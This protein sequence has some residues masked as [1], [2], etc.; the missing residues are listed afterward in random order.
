MVQ[1]PHT[2]AMCVSDG[3]LS[4]GQGVTFP[5]W[6]N[7]YSRRFAEQLFGVYPEWAE[8]AAPDPWPNAAPGCFMLEVPSP[9]HPDRALSVSTARGEITVEF[10]AHG[11]HQHYDLPGD[12]EA[13]SFAEALQAI[14]DIVAE[15]K[16]LAT[17]FRD[18]EPCA[19]TLIPT[20]V[21]PDLNGYERV[22][23]T[24][25]CGTYDRSVPV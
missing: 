21:T 9:M 24:S 23:Y 6:L 17:W 7:E 12:W 16:M 18:G 2:C 3:G 20:G 11:W 5:S 13:V 15:R 25:W 19:M 1:P 14:A 22:E 8:R 4:N 10:G